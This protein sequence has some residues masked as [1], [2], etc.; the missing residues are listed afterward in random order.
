MKKIYR[1]MPYFILALTVA[2]SQ[3]ENKFKAHQVPSNWYNSDSQVDKKINIDGENSV[4]NEN[5]KLLAQ[6]IDTIYQND[7]QALEMGSFEAQ[8]VL[9][10]LLPSKKPVSD[11]KPK[12]WVPWRAEY[13]MTDLS[14]TGSGVIGVLAL[15]GTATVRAFWRKQG[16]PETK[17][18]NLAESSLQ[19][20]NEDVFAGPTVP[21]N[22]SSTPEQ[23]VVQLE[24]AIK[25][26]VA[27]GK[28]KD[29]EI[30]RKNLLNAAKDFHAIATFIPSTSEDLPW[31]VSRFRLDFS[32][33][34]SGRVEPVGFVGGEAQ[35]RFEWHRIKRTESSTTQP[36]KLSMEGLSEKQINIRKSIQEFIQSTAVDLSEAFEDHSKFGFKAHQMRMGLGI[37]IKGNIGLIK[38]S[39]GVVGQIY[40]TR[41]V[42]R[43][44]VRKPKLMT[45]STEEYITLI[46]RNP[47]ENHKQFALNNQIPFET[48][49]SEDS[50]FEEVIYKFNRQQFRN[51]I[52]KAAHIGEFFAE[53]AS[54]VEVQSWKIYELRTALDMSISGVLDLVTLVG[55]GTAQIS[56]FNQNF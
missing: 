6:T 37:S 45:N 14:L 1:L 54:K 56:F 30:L 22:E 5:T 42:A 9:T 43:P 48:N 3:K 40:F 28:I 36:K 27:T 19:T 51:G 21:V 13:F 26:A 29:N 4:Q 12:D 20:S 24:P 11:G 23:M 2:C 47:S 25:A 39:A 53:R 38:G 34:A 7:A 49:I 52:K 32:I 8:A 41:D 35:F 55:S 31:W 46:E 50:G 33:D 10:P 15:K 18:S 16:P 44:V 17:K